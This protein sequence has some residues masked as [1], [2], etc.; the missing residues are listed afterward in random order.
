MCSNRSWIVHLHDIL[1]FYEG[2]KRLRIEQQHTQILQ[3]IQE[4]IHC[5][6]MPFPCLCK[7]IDRY[8]YKGVIILFLA[9]AYSLYQVVICFMFFKTMFVAF[10]THSSYPF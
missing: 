2:G 4:V 8:P 1:Q 5:L 10:S 6:P 3:F 9:C 7:S